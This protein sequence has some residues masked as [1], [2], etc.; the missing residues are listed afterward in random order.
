MTDQQMFMIRQAKIHHSDM[1]AAGGA[2]CPEA[3]AALGIV[4]ALQDAPAFPVVA[5]VRGALDDFVEVLTTMPEGMRVGGAN[6][7]DRLLAVY[8]TFCE[9]RKILHSPDSRTKEAWHHFTHVGGYDV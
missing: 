8:E 7:S 5:T 3:K 9:D 1:V 6:K 2:D 4:R